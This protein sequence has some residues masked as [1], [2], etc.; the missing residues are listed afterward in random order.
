MSGM[1]SGESR[2]K[3]YVER[4]EDMA[5]RKH[6]QF[7]DVCKRIYRNRLGMIGLVIV[8]LIIFSAVF[9]GF[10]T[11]YD[12]SAQDPTSRLLFPSWEHPMGTDNYGRDLF[13]RILYGGRISLLVALL[14]VAI[15]T[16]IGAV[17]GAIAGY[18]GGI[19]ETI[20]MRLMDILMAIPQLLM[21]IALSAALGGGLFNTAL[22]CAVGG[23]PA[24]C[25]IVRATV[26]S[27]RD[28][29]YVEAAHATGSN[30]A[31]IIWVYII[32][33]TL[34]PMLVDTTLRIGQTITAI[35]GLSFVG[36]GVQPPTPE[37]GSILATSRQYIR[38][39][40]PLVLFPGLM[41]MLTLFGFNVF[42]DALRDALDPKLK[43]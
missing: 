40:Y 27:I 19:A 15:S 13:S 30:N 20:I 17:L 42:G 1:V 24:S 21:A 36:L 39:F 9:A 31:R 4:L 8:F 16:V 43:Q 7:G 10:L 5:G 38:D 41:I 18:F 25:R 6:S 14:S 35:A 29:E 3:R 2:K 23:I 12:Y 11:K 22:A 33:N 37:W 32:P 28:S 34:A 26:M